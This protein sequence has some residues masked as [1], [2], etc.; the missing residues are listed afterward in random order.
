MQS[1][2]ESVSNTTA[3]IV[4]PHEAGKKLPGNKKSAVKRM[5]PRGLP[6]GMT[7]RLATICLSL[8]WLAI[9]IGTHLPGGVSPR[10]YLNDKVIHFGAY[11]GLAFLLSWAI[12]T[13][14]DRMLLQVLIVLT[15]V[16]SYGCFD[17]ISQKFVPG[18]NCSFGDLLADMLGGVFGVAFY[19][20]CRR[21][22][23]S[24]SLGTRLIDTFSR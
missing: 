7:I 18:R 9:F 17:E 21:L 13:R 4:A 14:K 11:A 3:A 8:Y 1:I 12:P 22:L 20:V 16:I 5:P 15:A 24:T 2:A 23:T 19:L 10:L 6:L